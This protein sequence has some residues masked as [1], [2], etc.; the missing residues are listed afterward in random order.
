MKRVKYS[1]IIDSRWSRSQDNYLITL[2]G[3]SAF[4]DLTLVREHRG[5]STSER[6][7][8]IA[9]L[10]D[11]ISSILVDSVDEKASTQR[12]KDIRWL[13][14]NSSMWVFDFVR[15]CWE[16]NL[17]PL[18]LRKLILRNGKISSGRRPR[19]LIKNRAA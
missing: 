17:N 10:K 14:S 5:H 7:L 8:M 13:R 18:R 2:F 19:G 9:M 16:L 6:R 4:D 11:V 12:R 1:K 15:V 3:K